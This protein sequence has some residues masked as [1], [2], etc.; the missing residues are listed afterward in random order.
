MVILLSVIFLMFLGSKYYCFSAKDFGYNIIV[1]SREALANLF[2][3]GNY[4][5][6]NWNIILAKKRLKEAEK[7]V[8]TK[9][10]KND[11][12]LLNISILRFEKF[13]YFYNV[14]KNNGEDINYFVPESNDYFE[15][16]RKIRTS[17]NV[18]YLN[19]FD[20]NFSKIKDLENKIILK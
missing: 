4:D 11:I 9:C 17:F 8:S 7:N 12:N 18:S 13:Y 10:Q 5:K 2:V 15:R 14:S 3:F 20:T 1:R 16:V 19:K 6:A